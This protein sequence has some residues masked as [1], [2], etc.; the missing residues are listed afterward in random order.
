MRA[1]QNLNADLK[2]S[3]MQGSISL[4]GNSG[5]MCFVASLGLLASFCSPG[6]CFFASHCDFLLLFT[7]ANTF[8]CTCHWPLP[9]WTVSHQLCLHY[10]ASLM[11]FLQDWVVLFF[12]YPPSF[13]KPESSESVVRLRVSA[14]VEN[15]PSFIT[16]RYGRRH[17]Q[18]AEVCSPG[19]LLEGGMGTNTWCYLV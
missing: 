15:G 13:L 8:L 14:C 18:L 5:I 2:V 17:S 4:S 11:A 10:T 6:S 9:Q 1:S 16:G 12:Q 3:F 7:D 19:R